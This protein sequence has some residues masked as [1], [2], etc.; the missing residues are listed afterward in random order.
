METLDDIFENAKN[1]PKTM[2]SYR[3][4][5]AMVS[6]IFLIVSIVAILILFPMMFGHLFSIIQ[7]NTTSIP[8]WSFVSW[9]IGIGLLFVSALIGYCLFIVFKILS[10]FF[11]RSIIQ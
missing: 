10:H 9:I 11:Q 1:D 6:L 4:V 3:F 7:Q 5:C 8:F 2:L